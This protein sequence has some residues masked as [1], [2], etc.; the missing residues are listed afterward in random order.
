MN[1]QIIDERYRLA[2]EQYAELGV[3]TEAGARRACPGARFP[4][5]AGRETTSAGSRPA[6]DGI[7]SGGI[8]A[9]GNYPG[10]ART[11]AEL[12]AGPGERC[13]RLL[14]GRHRLALH[15]IYGDFGGKRGGP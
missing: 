8:A 7:L 6:A 4:S 5:T 1:D 3:D 13:G 10:K 15:M 2:R 11:M 9:T 14:P 12:R